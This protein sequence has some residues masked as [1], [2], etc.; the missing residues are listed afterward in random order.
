ME[1]LS[2]NPDN[3]FTLQLPKCGEKRNILES[4]SVTQAQLDTEQIC[5][6]TLLATHGYLDQCKK[7][8]NRKPD[9]DMYDTKNEA[10]Q[11]LLL[12]HPFPR[13]QGPFENCMTGLQYKRRGQVHLQLLL[14]IPTQRQSAMQIVVLKQPNCPR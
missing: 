2:T 1:Y 13:H 14:D 11:K 4:Y 10:V 7:N 3:A 6:N 8:P 12:N 9:Y 5:I